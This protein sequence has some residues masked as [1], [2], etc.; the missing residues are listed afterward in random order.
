MQTQ[1]LAWV[2][3]LGLLAFTA[4]GFI[5]P[6][7]RM[8]QVSY[9][10]LEFG[11]GIALSWS[12]NIAL[13]QILFVVII[14]RN[15]LFSS[16]K[17]WAIVTLFS[18]LVCT[19]C[20]VHRLQNPSIFAN[21]LATQIWIFGLASVV[22][23]TLVVLFLQLLIQSIV[24]ESQIKRE[25]TI[26]NHRLQQY[27]LQVED[28]A[29]AQERNRIAR[30]IHDSLGHLL[31]VFNLHLGAALRLFHS[32]PQESEALL[33]ELQQIGKQAMDE[34]TRSVSQLRCDPFED[35]SLEE[36]I[37]TLTDLFQRSSN[38][39]LTWKI[40]LHQPI[41]KPQKL[42]LYRIVQESLTN[43][44]KYS[45]ASTV[46]FSITQIQQ[47]VEVIIQDNGRGFDLNN[48]T[49]GYG[50]QGMRERILALSGHLE[51]LTAIDQGCQIVARFPL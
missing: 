30:E 2:T 35:L 32:R 12:G 5:I 9:T 34:V 33:K 14:I 8:T 41:S 18:L 16:Q 42:T 26:A 20:Q 7:T 19:I 4:M 29:I 6:Q 17:Y 50:L 15:C 43:I 38:I 45:G 31:T 28:L 23:F 25:L 48:M 46:E 11:L 44:S 49:T 39:P 3:L 21:A 51:I 36:S 40:A 1:G 13:F 37:A 22:M 27:A 24:T 47:E 10:V